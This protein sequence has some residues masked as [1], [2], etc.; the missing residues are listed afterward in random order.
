MAVVLEILKCTH[1]ICLG[2]SDSG[3]SEVVDYRLDKVGCKRLE[4]V[5]V[6]R[7]TGY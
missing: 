7:E 3:R 1:E 6:K 5:A 2:V 4:W